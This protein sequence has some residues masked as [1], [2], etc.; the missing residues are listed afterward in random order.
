MA[1]GVHL[2]LS[3]LEVEVPPGIVTSIIDYIDC[4]MM[5]IP[6][7][8]QPVLRAQAAFALSVLCNEITN[9]LDDEYLPP[10]VFEQFMEALEASLTTL[11][12]EAMAWYLLAM[13]G[14]AMVRR[15]REAEK[16]TAAQQK[17][18]EGPR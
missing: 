2:M 17:G 5:E 12:C 3:E 15:R 4:A 10:I 11:P 16:S 1:F 13:V 9:V 7:P 8:L 18:G 6:P 14:S